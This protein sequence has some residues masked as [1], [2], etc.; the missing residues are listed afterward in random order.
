[1]KYK[2]VKK[3]NG[4]LVS[5]TIRRPCIVIYTPGVPV[6]APEFMLEYDY[7]LLTFDTLDQARMMITADEEGREIWECEAND[8]VELPP[9]LN[10]MHLI[11]A[12]SKKAKCE[13]ILKEWPEG[14]RMYKEVILTRRV[15]PEEEE[16]KHVQVG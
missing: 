9:Y 6:Q 4:H 2:V 12:G 10:L 7:H 3:R 1:M 14:T 11:Q 13:A 5:L 15:H 16:V 8:E